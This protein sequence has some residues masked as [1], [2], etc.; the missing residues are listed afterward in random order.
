MGEGGVSREPRRRMAS[1]AELR[2]ALASLR[3]ELRE[4]FVSG[5][6]NPAARDS[7]SGRAREGPSG[8]DLSDWERAVRGLR[9]RV[10][11]LGMR[12]HLRE[13]DDFGADPEA[14]EALRPWLDGLYDYYW[15]IEARGAEDLPDGPVLLVARRSGASPWDGLMIAHAAERARRARPRFAVADWLLEQPFARSRL[16]RLGGFS[17][18]PENAQR[19]L[20]RGHS[21][22]VFPEAAESASSRTG[23]GRRLGHADAVRIAAASDAPLV[24]VGVDGIG[25]PVA[26]LPWPDRGCIHFGGPF[27]S[28]DTAS[29][30]DEAAAARLGDELRAELRRCASSARRAVPAD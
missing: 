19:L 27:A 10:S 16:E 1:D 20:C 12:D 3:R 11:Q 7:D 22:V 15:R 25:G 13:V 9:R 24:P 8:D 6:G 21:V 28:R 14:L 29:V 4:R 5:A 2:E 18:R 23:S 30:S 26:A 17:A